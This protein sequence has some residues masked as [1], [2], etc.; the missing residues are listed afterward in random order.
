MLKSLPK[1]AWVGLGLLGVMLLMMLI[2]MILHRHVQGT[3][4]GCVQRC[5]TAGFQCG[6]AVPVDFFGDKAK[7]YCATWQELKQ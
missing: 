6:K 7:C 5:R 3:L 1:T 2:A 4:E